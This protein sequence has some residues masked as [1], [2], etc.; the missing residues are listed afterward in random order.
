MLTVTIPS[1]LSARNTR[2]AISPRFA[3]RTFL[4]CFIVFFLSFFIGLQLAFFSLIPRA[5]TTWPKSRMIVHLPHTD[6]MHFWFSLQDF[7]EKCKIKIWQLHFPTIVKKITMKFAR[8]QI[9]NF[10]LPSFFPFFLSITDKNCIK[11]FLFHDSH[12][13]NNLNTN[14]KHFFIII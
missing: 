3:T 9:A 8:F 4:N 10:I 2:M 11:T 14:R 7:S 1:S 12:F 13:F 6:Y 5:I